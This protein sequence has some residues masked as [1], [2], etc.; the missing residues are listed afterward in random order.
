MWIDG[1]TKDNK[2]KR[3]NSKSNTR[4]PEKQEQDAS[5][6]S[7]KPKMQTNADAFSPV[8]RSGTATASSYPADSASGS[9]KLRDIGSHCVTGVFHKKIDEGA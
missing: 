2:N 6:L 4:P 9:A 8:T 1:T 5:S 3:S 7:P